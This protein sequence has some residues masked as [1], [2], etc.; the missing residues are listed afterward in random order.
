MEF[1]PPWR[2][3]CSDCEQ[4]PRSRSPSESSWLKHEQERAPRFDYTLSILSEHAYKCVLRGV[5]SAEC[6]YILLACSVALRAFWEPFLLACSFYIIFSEKFLYI[7]AEKVC[8]LVLHSC[9]ILFLY[10]PNILFFYMGKYS[11]AA[12]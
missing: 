7:I 6:Y 5:Y 9:F 4:D 12:V 3:L 10:L 1:I 11:A 8:F 2:V